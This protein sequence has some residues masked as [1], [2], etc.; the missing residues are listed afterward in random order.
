M[1]W[2]F[3]SLC[4]KRANHT[5]NRFTTWLLLCSRNWQNE[6][7][8][9][10]ICFSNFIRSWSF[11]QMRPVSINKQYNRNWK[12]IRTHIVQNTVYC[13][14]SE[15]PVCKCKHSRRQRTKSIRNK[16]IIARIWSGIDSIQ[17]SAVF[18]LLDS[19]PRGRITTIQFRHSPNKM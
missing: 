9:T 5:H 4:G 3:Q 16:R 17:H 1:V 13:A 7:Y 2:R 8:W 11:V 19:R 18:D 14:L 12:Q 15:R 10:T 6:K